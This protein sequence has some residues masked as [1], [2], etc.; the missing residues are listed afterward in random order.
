MNY[1]GNKR[2]SS[3]AGQA[4][5][6]NEASTKGVNEVSEIKRDVIPKLSLTETVV[7]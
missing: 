3:F 1:S 4:F 5:P 6:V 2:V 7:G